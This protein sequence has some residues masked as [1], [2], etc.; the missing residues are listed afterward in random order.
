MSWF[1]PNPVVPVRAIGPSN[2][3]MRV[4][5]VLDHYPELSESYIQ[6]EIRILGEEYEIF[7]VSAQGGRVVPNPAVTFP[8]LRPVPVH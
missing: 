5:Y 2:P 3:K 7:I 1:R 6:T 8:V 4:L